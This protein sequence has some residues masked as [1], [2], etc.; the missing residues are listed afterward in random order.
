[1]DVVGSSRDD[2]IGDL[3]ERIK[4]KTLSK[5]VLKKLD[6]RGAKICLEINRKWGGGAEARTLTLEK[7]GKWGVSNPTDRKKGNALTHEE[8]MAAC[9]YYTCCLFN[10]PCAHLVVNREKLNFPIHLNKSHGSFGA[11]HKRVISLTGGVNFSKAEADEKMDQYYK[12]GIQEAIEEVK[13]VIMGLRADSTKVAIY[14]RRV[15]Q[16][17]IFLVW[18]KLAYLLPTALSATASAIYFV[19][20][21]SVQYTSEF[22]HKLRHFFWHLDY[23]FI[24]DARDING[25]FSKCGI[26]MHSVNTL[27]CSI[28]TCLGGQI[29]QEIVELRSLDCSDTLE[30]N[31]CQPVT[32]LS[33]SRSIMAEYFEII[34]SSPEARYEVVFAAP[35]GNFAKACNHNETL[36]SN[37]LPIGEIQSMLDETPGDLFWS[38]L[39]DKYFLPIVWVIIVCLLV[40]IGWVSFLPNLKTG[41]GELFGSSEEVI[42]EMNR[43]EILDEAQKKGQITQITHSSLSVALGELD[44]AAKE[45]TSLLDILRSSSFTFDDVEKF[46]SVELKHR[47][48]EIEADLLMDAL[49]NHKKNVGDGTNSDTIPRV[50]AEKLLLKESKIFE[51][52]CNHRLSKHPYFTTSFLI[53]PREQDEVMPRLCAKLRDKK[54]EFASE[55]H[56]VSSL[57]LAKECH[58]AALRLQHLNDICERAA[59]TALDCI[60][61]LDDSKSRKF[62]AKAY[63]K[64]EDLRKLEERL[65][66]GISEESRKTF[67]LEL[68]HFGKGEFTG[69]SMERAGKQLALSGKW[70]CTSG[71]LKGW[72]YQGPFDD[73]SQ[74]LQPLRESSWVN[75]YSGSPAQYVHETFEYYDPATKQNKVT[76]IFS[77]FRVKT[78]SSIMAPTTLLIG[79]FVAREEQTHLMGSFKQLKK[80]LK[81]IKISGGKQHFHALS[82]LRASFLFH[83]ECKSEKLSSVHAARLIQEATGATLPYT[84]TTLRSLLS[85]V[86]SSLQTS[87]CVNVDVCELS[88]AAWILKTPR[89]FCRAVFLSHCPQSS[90]HLKLLNWDGLEIEALV[91]LLSSPDEEVFKTFREH[92]FVKHMP[93]NCDTK[94]VMI[95]FA[96]FFLLWEDA[97][98]SGGCRHFS[99]PKS[100]PGLSA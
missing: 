89:E 61:C 1:M 12:K 27:T 66:S 50:T 4:A 39:V 37:I 35:T 71:V 36:W 46:K 24:R 93:K 21:T 48:L 72:E 52:F 53:S 75:V 31:R 77:G 90:P 2:V 32:K 88:M 41:L 70:V 34:S 6:D 55:F 47:E 57:H 84:E 100:S 59:L 97:R 20:S 68:E 62:L 23:V 26:F 28:A 49:T 56:R 63:D 86:F 94:S 5:A 95:D 10:Q 58:S 29:D 40:T 99:T 51:K 8:V 14:V 60:Y 92:K 15:T 80:L 85:F 69:I 78:M 96:D 44:S 13:K 43:R 45:K 98:D 25:V 42:K 87:P 3:K 38:I 17:A 64:E 7:D 22:H 33:L 9:G 82:Y 54:V 74:I 81:P 30:K 16:A 91:K 18:L 19:V 73:M 11:K 76:G 67:P 83:N 79:T 65:D